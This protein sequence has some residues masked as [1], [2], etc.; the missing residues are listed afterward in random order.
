MRQSF[1]EGHYL[2]TETM[3]WYWDLYAPGQGV[4]L[5]ADADLGA[6]PLAPA[7]VL[8]AGFDPLR[9]D[10]RRYVDALEQ[11]GVEAELLEFP[12]QIHGFVRFTAVM[13]QALEALERV[14]TWLRERL[15]G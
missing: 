8:T 2:E 15:R 3:H 13:P 14:G 7:L 4:D 12:G 10:G 6:S 11:A 5:L 1:A 9:D